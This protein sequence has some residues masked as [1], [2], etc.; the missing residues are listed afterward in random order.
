LKLSASGRASGESLSDTGKGSLSLQQGSRPVQQQPDQ[1]KYHGKA[2]N[3][4]EPVKE[5]DMKVMFSDRLSHLYNAMNIFC[6]RANTMADPL[7]LHHSRRG[8][9]VAM[10]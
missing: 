1:D 8:R 2:V 3:D 4:N 7:P 6:M 10:L 5:E 9:R